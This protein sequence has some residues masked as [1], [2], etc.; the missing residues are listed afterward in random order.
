M[1]NLFTALYPIVNI[2]FIVI[3]ALVMSSCN[4]KNDDD[5]SLVVNW[6]F[7]SGD[8]TSNNIET[9]QVKAI[10]ESDDTLKGNTSC[11]AGSI[12]LGSVSSGSYSIRVQ[13]MD[14]N[15][16]VRAEN[17]GY[18]V[19]IQ[20][21]YSPDLNVTIYPK[22][23]NVNVSWNGCPS[24]VILPYYI[25]LYNPPE[26]AGDTPTDEVKSTQESCSS[27]SA[28]LTSV[29]PGDYIIELDSRAVTPKVYDTKQVTV[30]AGEDLD[31]TFDLP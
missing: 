8:C 28:T 13:G 21:G 14:A 3:I 19:T 23:S 11:S 9:I 22:S 1:K 25:T 17:Y 27:G 10:P 6:Q 15:D 7:S 31:V 2:G 5:A 4:D 18:S 20:G 30:V 24:G 26:Q 29:Q 16:I 12:D